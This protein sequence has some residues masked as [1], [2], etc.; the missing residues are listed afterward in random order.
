M[1]KQRRAPKQSVQPHRP[2]GRPLSEVLQERPIHNGSVREHNNGWGV[3]RVHHES[4]RESSQA[5]VKK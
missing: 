3:T 5:H 2:A 1:A 4:I